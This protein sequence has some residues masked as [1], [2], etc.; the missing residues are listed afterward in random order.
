MGVSSRSIQDWEN[1]NNF[2][3]IQRLQALIA[4]LAASGG[5][6]VGQELAEAEALWAAAQRDARRMHTPF[7]PAWFAGLS[8]HQ[9][10]TG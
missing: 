3:S 1:G 7:D 4:V 6:A 2:P 8:S 5:L 10:G 9:G